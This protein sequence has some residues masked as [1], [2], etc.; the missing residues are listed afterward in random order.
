VSTKASE[1]RKIFTDRLRQ[2]LRAGGDRSHAVSDARGTYREAACLLTRFDPMLLRLPGESRA[3][4]GAVLELLDDCTTMGVKDRAVW[5]LK[6]D[7]RDEA[8]RGLAG[9]EAG[10][11]MGIVMR[12]LKANSP[13]IHA[14][15]ETA[16]HD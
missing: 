3:T 14:E 12:H 2:E 4:G 5:N 16:Q 13:D 6:A 9:P 7:V 11:Q 10:T 8:L 1:A 15:I